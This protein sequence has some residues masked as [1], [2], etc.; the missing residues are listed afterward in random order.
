[1]IDH[2]KQKIVQNKAKLQVGK[3]PLETGYF[4]QNQMAN[5]CIEF[6]ISKGCFRDPV[7]QTLRLLV[8]PIMSN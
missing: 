7:C 5:I 6:L 8:S 2:D 4:D 1:M 3:K